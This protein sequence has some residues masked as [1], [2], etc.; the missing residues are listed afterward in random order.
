LFAEAGLICIVALISPYRDDRDQARAAAGE[1]LFLEIFVNASI[2]KM[3]GAGSERALPK[4]A[5]SADC[6]FHGRGRA[7]RAARKPRIWSSIQAKNQSR[8]C[9]RALRSYISLRLGIP[10]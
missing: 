7:V 8:R 10:G 3:R 1:H 5:R 2:E 4:G 6:R 9:E